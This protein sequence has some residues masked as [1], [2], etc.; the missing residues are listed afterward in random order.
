MF[1]ENLRINLDPACILPFLC[2]LQFS[3]HFNSQEEFMTA[4]DMDEFLEV[5][6]ILVINVNSEAEKEGEEE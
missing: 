3:I 5:R 4:V 6:N 1:T 2:N